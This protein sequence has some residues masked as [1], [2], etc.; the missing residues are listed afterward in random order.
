MNDMIDMEVYEFQYV[1]TQTVYSGVP[2]KCDIIIVYSMAS[3]IDCHKF[4]L[5]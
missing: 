3:Y 1:E 4:M 5:N 2:A